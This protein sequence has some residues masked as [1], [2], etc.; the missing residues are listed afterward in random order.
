MRGWISA[1]KIGIREWVCIFYYE[2]SFS[3]PYNESKTHDAFIS[4]STTGAARPGGLIA[5]ANAMKTLT[6]SLSPGW[7]LSA[8]KACAVP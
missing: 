3:I 8:A 4:P 5:G 1:R 6:F 7:I 2:I